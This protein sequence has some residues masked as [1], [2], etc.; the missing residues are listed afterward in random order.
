LAAA[1]GDGD[2]TLASIA[3]ASVK[4]RDAVRTEEIDERVEA[5]SRRVLRAVEHT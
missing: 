5:M 3:A 4:V 1:R 2:G